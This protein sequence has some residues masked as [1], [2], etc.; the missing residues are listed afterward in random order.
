ML[1]WLRK[2]EVKK[3]DRIEIGGVEI[4]IVYKNIKN[5]H[6]RILPPD[7]KVRITT[8]VRISSE[9]LF[10]FVQSRIDWIKKNQQKIINRNKHHLNEY[11][12]GEI[13]YFLGNKYELNVIAVSGKE[14]IIIDECIITLY[15]KINSTKAQ[16]KKILEDFYRDQLKNIIPN[17]IN[18]WEKI[19][20]V[21]V[22]E[23][24]VKRMK[25][26]WGTCNIRAARIWLNL[27][28][29]KKPIDVLEYIIVHEMIHLLERS[30][31]Q[32]F[33][34]LMSKYLPNWKNL[35]KQLKNFPDENINLDY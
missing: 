8:P 5:I 7:G 3:T 32:R 17:Y 29:V 13:H 9:T 35:E 11:R 1:N 28:L 19:L 21:Q 22:N 10:S 4:D 26:R 2:R 33:K 14:K 12:N 23:F 31:N 18:K 34:S 24:G 30:H 6:L 16:R 25:T 15:T 27:E 20:N